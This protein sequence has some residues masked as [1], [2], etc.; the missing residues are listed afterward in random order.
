MAYTNVCFIYCIQSFYLHKHFCPG[1][2]EPLILGAVT[3]QLEETWEGSSS[4]SVLT[5]GEMGLVPPGDFTA[6]ME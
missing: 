1:A 4:F 2:A 6:V 3:S 5:Q